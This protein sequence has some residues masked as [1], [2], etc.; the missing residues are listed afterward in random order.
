V[1][2][3][4]NV[5]YLL[6]VCIFI[7]RFEGKN[8][9]VVIVIVISS[10]T[11]SEDAVEANGVTAWQKLGLVENQQT[12]R[13]SDRLVQTTQNSGRASHT[14]NSIDYTYSFLNYK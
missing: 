11:D 14:A 8:R 9:A 12:Y 3:H 7:C 13:A 6:R 4:A 5:R 10:C 1:A 2:V